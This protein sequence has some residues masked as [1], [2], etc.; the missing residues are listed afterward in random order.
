MFSALLANVILLAGQAVIMHFSKDSKLGSKIEMTFFQVTGRLVLELWLI[1][2]LL[3]LWTDG[4]PAAKL[5][6]LGGHSV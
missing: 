4:Q 3:R 5:V 2:L 6:C 1:Q